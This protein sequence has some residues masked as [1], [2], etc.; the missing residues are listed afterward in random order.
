MIL[1]VLRHY[2]HYLILLIKVVVTACYSNSQEGD[3]FFWTW[4]PRT[5]ALISSY[6]ITHNIYIYI[7]IIY[8]IY[9]YNI[10]YIYI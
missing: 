1:Q 7:Y 5:D 8:I 10:I 9:I 4:Q 3:V 6:Y 2:Y